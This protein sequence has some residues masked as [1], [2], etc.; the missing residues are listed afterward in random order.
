[1]NKEKNFYKVGVVSTDTNPEK[2]ET[3]ISNDWV[4]M[5]EIR[6]DMFEGDLGQ[7]TLQLMKRIHPHIPLLATFRAADEGGQKKISAGER[8]SGIEAAIPFCD[9]VDIECFSTDINAEVIA[10]AK[11][12][13]KSVIVSFHDFEATPDTA[14]LR[15]IIEQAILLGAGHVKLACTVQTQVDLSRLAGLFA[16]HPDIHL[17]ILGMGPLGKASRL[18]FPLLGS[19]LAFVAIDGKSAPGQWDAQTYTKLLEDM[20]IIR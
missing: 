18:L 10:L 4:D 12:A 1:M 11:A 3:A 9:W 13:R 7:L 8:F 19:E 14:T 16:E 6:L 20:G 15:S 17:S 2:I 5:L